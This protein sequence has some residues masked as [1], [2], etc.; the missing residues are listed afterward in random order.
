[1][2]TLWYAWRGLLTCKGTGVST[3]GSAWDSSL[4]VSV[5][6]SPPTG[7]QKGAVGEGAVTLW[8]EKI[9]WKATPGWKKTLH[10]CSLN[11]FHVAKM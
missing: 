2:S 1:M 4:Q 6:I 8:A 3:E 11:R 9:L 10:P 7:K 5:G